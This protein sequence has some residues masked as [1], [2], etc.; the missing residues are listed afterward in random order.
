MSERVLSAADYGRARPDVETN[1]T[2]SR[3]SRFAQKRSRSSSRTFRREWIRI[4]SALCSAMKSAARRKVPNAHPVRERA[5]LRQSAT[6]LR[7]WRIQRP[8]DAAPSQFCTPLNY[9]SHGIAIVE[10]A[11]ASDRR[12]RVRH[13]S[14][15]FNESHS[16]SAILEVGGAHS[17]T[18]PTGS[19]GDRAKGRDPKSASAGDLS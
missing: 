13:A 17:N 19:A 5:S 15:S 18:C 2:N 1:V 12:L 9:T 4:T 6:E 3:I 7:R 8:S 16:A 14:Q 10:D 11:L